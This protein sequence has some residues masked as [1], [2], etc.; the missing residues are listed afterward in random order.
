MLWVFQSFFLDDFYKT[1]KLRRADNA[2]NYVLSNVSD[3]EEEFDKT[4]ARASDHYDVCIMVYNNTF[5]S[6]ISYEAV[7]KCAL[8]SMRTNDLLSLYKKAIDNGGTFTQRFFFV[9]LDGAQYNEDGTLRNG[10][11]NDVRPKYES[12]IKVAVLTNDSGSQS[13][14]FLDSEISPLNETVATLRIQ[15]IYITVIMIAIAIA[16]AFAMSSRITKPIARMNK[17]AAALAGGD[18][19]VKFEDD[20]GQREIDEL[21]STLNFAA[22][23]LSKVDKLRN[24]LISNISHDLRTPLTLIGGYAELM[25]DVPGENTPENMDLII[26]ETKRLSVLVNDVL[27]LSKYRSE[28]DAL[29]KTVYCLTDSV[30]AILGRYSKL[31]RSQGYIIRFES[32]E[33]IYVEADEGKIAQVLYNLI[34]NAINYTG[35]DKT[36]I[37]RQ[38]I[39]GSFVKIEVSDSGVGIDGEDLP[40]IFERYY[41][42]KK[43]HKRPLVGTGLGLSIVKSILDSHCAAYGVVSSEDKGSTLWFRLRIVESPDMQ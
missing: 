42:S 20:S 29:N 3:N 31:I 11:E 33:N 2:M 18:Y 27:D 40:F 10:Q 22:G 43:M 26:D 35:D 30:M 23:E 8:H 4:I 14:V 6:Y 28:A 12:Y 36:V 15:L 7:P 32:T 1:I 39:E 17:S 19:G 16:L 9:K 5:E 38:I 41:R 37:V 24:E 13:V 21:G 25:R 34:N